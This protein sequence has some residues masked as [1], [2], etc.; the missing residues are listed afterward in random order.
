M[1]FKYK[2]GFTLIEIA[3]VMS[4]IGFLFF[5]MFG[6]YASI[7]KLIQN[8]SIVIKKSDQAL[9]VIAM[10][11][12]DLNNLYF[13]KW[14]TNNF[15]I[16]KKNTI[17]HDIEIDTLSFTSKSQYANSSTMQ[18]TAF[19][20]KYFGKYDEKTGRAYIFRQ[21]DPFSITSS[22]SGIPIPILEEVT[23]LQF[24]YS[25]NGTDWKTNWDSKQAQRAPSFIE[26]QMK[27]MEGNIE[28]SEI[29]S[30]SPYSIYH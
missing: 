8:Q 27:W 20:V 17:S 19:G 25:R 14:N 3:I 13:E 9:Y 5:T 6:T 7:Q 21:E 28:R 15:F 30:V 16:G 26:V 24:K 12:N 22:N 2:K 11:T 10:I 29:I 1:T 18:T 23:Q 4:L